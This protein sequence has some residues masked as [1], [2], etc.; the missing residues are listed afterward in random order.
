MLTALGQFRIEGIVT[1]ID[2]L[3]RVVDHDAFRAGHTHTGFV[4]EHQDGPD[5][6]PERRLE[7]AAP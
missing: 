2:F 6:P 1:N 5:A 3:R 7:K 4:D